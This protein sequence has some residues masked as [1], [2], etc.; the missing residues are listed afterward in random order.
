MN[1]EPKFYNKDKSLTDYALSCGYVERFDHDDDNRGMLFKEHGVYSV[2]GFHQGE[3]FHK[4][5][6]KLTEA[7]KFFYSLAH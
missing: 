1:T 5:F 7:R 4:V 6:H 3:H 2:R